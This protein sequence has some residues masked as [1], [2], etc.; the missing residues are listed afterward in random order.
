MLCST[1][2]RVGSMSEHKYF[3]GGL[4]QS[5]SSVIAVGASTVDGYYVA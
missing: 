4:L 1:Q 2:Q 5:Y 3:S